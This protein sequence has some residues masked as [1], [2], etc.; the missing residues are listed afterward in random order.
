MNNF[1]AKIVPSLYC[2]G[3]SVYFLGDFLYRSHFFG[4]FAKSTYLNTRVAE[5][6]KLTKGDEIT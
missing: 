6:F 3:E 1:F 2:L 5:T 4:D